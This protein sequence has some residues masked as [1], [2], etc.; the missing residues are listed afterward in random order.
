MKIFSGKM[1]LPWLGTLKNGSLWQ[2]ARISQKY[3]FSLNAVQYVEMD[4]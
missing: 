1:E 2:E 4:I 3:K